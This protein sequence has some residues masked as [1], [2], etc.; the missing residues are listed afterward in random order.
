MSWY[1][2]LAER[3]LMNEPAHRARYH[4]CGHLSACECFLDV[5][6]QCSDQVNGR[7][8]RERAGLLWVEDCIMNRC[9]R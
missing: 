9:P 4:Q 1:L 5:M 7:P 6:N 8:F 2:T 3:P